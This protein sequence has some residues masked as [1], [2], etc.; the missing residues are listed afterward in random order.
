MRPRKRL[1]TRP[2]MSEKQPEL[3]C[4]AELPS[5][6]L[7]MVNRFFR[8]NGH[9]GK[10]RGGERVFVLKKQSRETADSSGQQGNIIAALRAC[11]KSRGY[12]LRSVWVDLRMRRLGLGC[13]LLTETL[14]LLSPAPCWCYPYA[15]LE[16]FYLKSGF[17]VYPSDQVP[18][19]IAQPFERYRDQSHDFL[20]MAHET[21]KLAKLTGR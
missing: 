13:R 4:F 16:A 17:T 12:L 20:L 8:D 9:K 3:H 15:H 21:E 1:K 6:A 19:D 14:R 18:E 5:L 2:I 10:A 11:P 7:P